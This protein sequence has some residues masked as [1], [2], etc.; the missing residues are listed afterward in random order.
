MTKFR[1]ALKDVISEV[2]RKIFSGNFNLGQV[3]FPI[4]VMAPDS[5]LYFITTMSIHSPLYMNAAALATDPVERLKF[6]IVQSISFLYT[7]HNWVKPLNPI[8][9]ET[10]TC[11]H[12]DGTIVYME[13]VVHHPPISYML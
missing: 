6:V 2:G 8:L 5:I 3:S 4:Y 9:G 1:K 12:D 11:T 10:F 13:Q 7:T